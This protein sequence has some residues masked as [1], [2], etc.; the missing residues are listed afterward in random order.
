MSEDQ[1]QAEFWREVWNKY[2]DFR[3]HMWAVPNAA[4]GETINKKDFIRASTLKATGLLA[5]VW[6]LHVFWKGQFHIIETKVPGGSLTKDRI[7]NGK[8]TFGQKEWGEKMVTHG[9]ISHI[10]HNLAEGIAII[11]KI[12]L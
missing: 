12:L 9:A 11:E 7:A 10:Y 5:G 6:D 2:P 4:I 1:I 3:H 8:K